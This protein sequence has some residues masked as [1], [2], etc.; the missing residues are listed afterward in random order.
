[1][2]IPRDQWCISPRVR[3]AG[4]GRAAE[5]GRESIFCVANCKQA[6]TRTEDAARL[7]NRPERAPNLCESGFLCDSVFAPQSRTAPPC[8]NKATGFG[9][10]NDIGYARRDH[11][12]SSAGH[13]L[14]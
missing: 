4:R 9:G 12:G 6:S 1:M 5:P 2:E 7:K 13:L 8:C 10:A 3:E 14:K 11:P